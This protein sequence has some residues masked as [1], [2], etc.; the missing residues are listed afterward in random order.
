MQAAFPMVGLP[1][2][3]SPRPDVLVP[4]IATLAPEAVATDAPANVPVPALIAPC[5]PAST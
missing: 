2:M 5:P 1:E 4:G 3:V